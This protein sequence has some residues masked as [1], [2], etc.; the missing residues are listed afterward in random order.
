MPALSPPAPIADS[1]LIM[2]HAT[3]RCEECVRVQEYDLRNGV[4]TDRTVGIPG[5]RLLSLHLLDADKEYLYFLGK[6]AKTRWAT[7]RLKRTR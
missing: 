5:D 4:S 2:I 6:S 1:V 3:T 7:M